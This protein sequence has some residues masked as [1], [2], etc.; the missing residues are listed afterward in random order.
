MTT[1]E[2][3]PT[4]PRTLPGHV[5]TL[6][7]GAGFAGIGMAAKL[8][9]ADRNADVLVIERADEVGGTW[10]DNTY[11]GAA[12]DVPSVLYSFSFAPNPDW[13]HSY[14]RQPEIF[15]YLR[16]V[17]TSAGV[18]RNLVT[19][20]ELLGATWDDDAQLW[21][22]RTSLGELTAT[23]L[24]AATGT[25]S[26]PKLPA[27]PGLADFTGT[28]FHSATWNH[29]HDLRGERVAVVGTG[30]SAVQFV[31]EI[32]DDTEH[33]TVFQRTAAWACPRPD[34]SPSA[35]TR[36]LYR[37]VPLVQKL[38]RGGVYAILELLVLVLAHLTRLLP[39]ISVWPRRYLRKHVTDEGKRKALTPS[40]TL[41]CKRVLLTNTWVPTLARP[42]L[43]LVASGIHH[44]TERGVV[45]NDG[46]EHAV[47]T[48]IFGTGFTPTE[49]PVAHLLRGA[50]GQTLAE[51]WAGSPHA[52]L[53][54]T[55]AGF[56][57]LFLMY[58][59][60]TNLGHSSIVYMLE[61]QA[62]YIS[63]ALALMRRRELSSLQVL[64]T[65]Q[66]AY[67][68]RIDDQLQGTVWNAGG[69]SSWYLDASGRN[70]AMWPTFTWRYRQ[71]TKR[72]DP[73]RYQLVAANTQQA[74]NQRATTRPADVTPAS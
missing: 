14:S 72:F 56:P 66:Q 73:S 31:P 27:L 57:N 13:K 52:Y 63:D 74:T 21:R 38:V 45:D 16:N 59:P 50:D 49:P 3:A 53:G 40:F 9:R 17:A 28:T 54:T 48:I 65:E 71:L 6:V 62:A 69:C 41:G 37:R 43:T 4:R 24:I 67:N 26:Q 32:I 61:S 60:N 29:D 11:P 18:R 22:V 12:C 55:V 51:H 20:C 44:V 10:R 35:R 1:T 33:L 2:N 5:H 23:V 70:S 7:V 8:L 68:A 58:G 42:D 46:V 25:L 30:A 15:D 47:D 39:I 34:G 19:G 36:A 64:P